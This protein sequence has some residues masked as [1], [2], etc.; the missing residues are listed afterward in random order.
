MMAVLSA[1]K[2]ALVKESATDVEAS[3]D[4]DNAI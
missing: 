4:D 2:P 3:A 1:M